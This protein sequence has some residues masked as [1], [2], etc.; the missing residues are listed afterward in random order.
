MIKTLARL[1]YQKSRNTIRF[2][3]TKT[4]VTYGIS[5][6]F[7]GI[8]II[9]L[10]A[11]IASS[12][13]VLPDEFLSLTFS[14]LF[15]MLIGFVILLGVPQVFNDMYS[16]Q[17][18][19]HLFTL[20]IPTRNIFWVKFGQSF[21]AVPGFIWVVAVIFLTVYGIFAK[22]SLIFFPISYLTT[23]A[24]ILIGM[25]FA[26]LL[27]LI[28]V[29][30]IPAHRAK[31]LMTAMSAFAGIFAY[32]SF[33]LPSLFMAETDSN[34]L[35]AT[36]PELPKWLPL[37]WAADSIAYAKNG[38]F[39]FSLPF[40]LIVLLAIALLFL[41]TLLVERG[42]RTGWVRLS[43]GSGRKKSRKKTQ[44][45]ARN[46]LSHPI[47]QIGIK[48]WLSVKRDFREWITFLPIVFFMFF[49][50]V[51]L[52]GNKEVLEAIVAEPQITWS[53]MLGLFIFLYTILGSTFAATTIGREGESFYLLRVLP[54]NSWHL[55][56]GKF[57]IS[58][59]LPVGLL[60]T[61]QIIF[62]VLLNWSLSQI[63]I[64]I[65]VITIFGTGVTGI[66][67][68]FGT[69]GSRFNR[70]IPQQ[71][72]KVG[73]SFILMIVTFIYMS[74]ATIPIT[75]SFIPLEAIV[76]EEGW[77]TN[78]GGML[79]FFTVI[80]NWKSNNQ[81]LVKAIGSMLFL[82]ITLGTAWFTLFFSTIKISKGIEIEIVSNVKS[83]RN[84]L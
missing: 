33:Q 14:Y 47:I 22:A 42:F 46:K 40:I 76:I 25:A 29:Q 4:K 45:K 38:S 53:V 34:E 59:L 17:E 63:L 37:T 50:L 26:Y 68:A 52:I 18:L 71:R 39:S 30:I 43:E 11:M 23:L 60:A 80:L 3:P 67:L 2:A 19:E 48:E 13:T 6:L 65:I 8:F 15:A 12:A 1:Y 7:V 61:L 28:L 16:S 62:G 32:L 44:G 5:G 57:W 10:S 31:E 84:K 55:A 69:I 64:G 56:L 20:P 72:L 24:I 58:L 66:G 73:V 79:G 74:I 36:L 51:S 83:K 54:I 70:D 75:M 49:P 81:L 77:D 35:L 27:N 78:S 9:F 21:V 41:A 82:F